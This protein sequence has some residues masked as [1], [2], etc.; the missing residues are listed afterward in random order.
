MSLVAPFAVSETEINP[1]FPG[2]TVL[3]K[4]GC[5]QCN[6]TYRA[7]DGAGLLYEV[8]DVTQDDQALAL[9]HSTGI[10]SMPI[11]LD[12]DRSWGGFRP[13]MIQESVDVRQ[14]SAMLA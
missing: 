1:G 11:V 10:T 4:P 3:S 8:L 14:A 2:I 5:V 9:A 13:D 6:A 7:L 12:G